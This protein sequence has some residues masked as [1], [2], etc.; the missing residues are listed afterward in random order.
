MVN[1]C[2]FVG[3]STGE[4]IVAG[5]L[6]IPFNGDVPPVWPGKL[7]KNILK[8]D[9]FDSNTLTKSQMKSNLSISLHKTSKHCKILFVRILSH[10]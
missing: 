3:S 4:G 2:I 7:K 6:D 10:K 5:L 8:G 1:C 9:Q